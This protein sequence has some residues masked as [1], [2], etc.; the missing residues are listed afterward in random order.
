MIAAMAKPDAN[1]VALVLVVVTTLLVTGGLLV[2]ALLMRSWK[3]FDA[4]YRSQR[5]QKPTPDP[6]TVSGQRLKLPAEDDPDAQPQDDDDDDS[7]ADDGTSGAGH[8]G[9]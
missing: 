3:R 6:W 5:S 4:R 1:A 7:E 9:R 8:R 2:I